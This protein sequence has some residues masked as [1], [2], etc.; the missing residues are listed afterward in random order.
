VSDPSAPLSNKADFSGRDVTL[1]GVLGILFGSFLTGGFAFYDSYP[2]IGCI[3]ALIGG[4]GLIAMVI[5]LTWYRLKIIHAL[6]VTIAALVAT[7]AVF[8]Y[9][10]WTKPKEVIV[11]DAPTAEDIEKA[12]VPIKAERDAA[13][14]ARDT[15]RQ[16]LDAAQRNIIPPP[17]VLPP[18]PQPEWSAAE[19]AIRSDL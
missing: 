4:L 13:I 15:A 11:H 5:L 8:A 12:T 18:T 3:L 19:I 17:V 14:K 16:E 6:I 7:W 1:Y 2:I 10:L 9:V